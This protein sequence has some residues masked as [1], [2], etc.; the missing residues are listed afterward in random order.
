M[1]RKKANEGK[2]TKDEKKAPIETVVKDEEGKEYHLKPLVPN[3]DV[4]FYKIYL[5]CFSKTL[6]GVMSQKMRLVLWLI[7]K[8]TLT[9]ELKYSYREIAE[10]SHISYQTVADTMKTLIED[11]FIRRNGK[12][13][14]VNP[15]AVFRGRLDK[16]TAAWNKYDSLDP[17]PKKKKKGKGKAEEKKQAEAPAKN[18]K[19]EKELK[20]KPLSLKD[21]ND[22]KWEVWELSRELRRLETWRNSLMHRLYFDEKADENGELEQITEE[23]K[24]LRDRMKYFSSV[25]IA[26]KLPVES[27]EEDGDT[28]AEEPET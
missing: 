19:P 26:A 18:Q 1:G 28:Q 14:M 5:S 8:M 27:D 10:L 12:T 11:D 3:T 17:P 23:I 13:L 6:N 25:L 20:R 16:K 4:D 2:S 7:R 15:D 9:N 24:K 22:L 21:E